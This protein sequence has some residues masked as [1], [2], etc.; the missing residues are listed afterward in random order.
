LWTVHPSDAVQDC[1][2]T[3]ACDEHVS[4][5]E[6]FA[7]SGT[8]HSLAFSHVVPQLPPAH[9]TVQVAPLLQVVEQPPPAHVTLHVAPL[10]HSIAQPPA[11]HVRRHVLPV[12]HSH[13]SSA[14]QTVSPLV[15]ASDAH[16][17][18]DVASAKTKT[19]PTIFMGSA[20]SLPRR[21]ARCVPVRARRN[22]RVARRADDAR[23]H[24]A[25]DARSRVTRVA[26]RATDDAPQKTVTR[27]KHD[28]LDAT[29]QP[30]RARLRFVRAKAHAPPRPAIGVRV[31]DRRS[32]VVAQNGRRLRAIARRAMT[33]TRS[34]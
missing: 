11:G 16:A 12:A 26:P 27:A 28:A 19:M 21:D 23:L 1:S 3:S 6:P 25:R 10:L 4:A 31:R 22:W 20:S 13:A 18:C 32:R 8:R 2:Q 33:L 17:T 34:V 14:T 15:P 30:E 29:R 24:P 7:Q 9:E 5:Q